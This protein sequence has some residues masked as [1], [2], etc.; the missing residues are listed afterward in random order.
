MKIV[1]TCLICLAC[2]A[3]CVFLVIGIVNDAKTLRERKRLKAQ[4]KEGKI[5]ERKKEI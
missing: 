1:V 5:E 4:L 3:I 2:I